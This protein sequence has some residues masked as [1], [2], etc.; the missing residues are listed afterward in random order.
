[1]SEAIRLHPDNPRR[2][3][4]RGKATFLLGSTEHYGALLNTAFDYER[5]FDEIASM[6][7]NTSRI[8]AFYRE[9]ESS[10]VEMG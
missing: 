8:F 10:I 5:Y 6:G 3:L 2:F 1:M 4:W 7:L 9:L